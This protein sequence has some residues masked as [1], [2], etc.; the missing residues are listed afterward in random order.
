MNEQTERLWA[1]LR[2]VIQ[3]YPDL[4]LSCEC[5]DCVKEEAEFRRQILR[6][7]KEAKLTFPDGREIEFD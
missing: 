6:A 1:H 7:C 2:G 5:D 4:C 3:D